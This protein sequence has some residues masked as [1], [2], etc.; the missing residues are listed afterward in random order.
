[1]KAVLLDVP[2]QVRRR[3]NVSCQLKSGGRQATSTWWRGRCLVCEHLGYK[4]SSLI[5]AP[6]WIAE[7]GF[8]L[9]PRRSEAWLEST[10][11]FACWLLGS[12]SPSG[13]RSFSDNSSPK[14]QFSLCRCV[15][16]CL[17]CVCVRVCVLRACC[18]RV[19]VC[20]LVCVCVTGSHNKLTNASALLCLGMQL[21]C[22]TQNRTH[23]YPE[24][25]AGLANWRQVREQVRGKPG[26]TAA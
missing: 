8:A 16:V 1:M 11:F 19:C 13:I 7:R 6:W 12:L 2:R 9:V 18:V 21:Q 23:A 3:P 25:G 20:V 26:R 17:V 10:A 15:C 5:R 24:A 4:L 22:A 14:E